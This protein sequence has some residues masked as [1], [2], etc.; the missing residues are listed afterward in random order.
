MSRATPARG[1]VP[2]PK[3][4]KCSI[5]L[6]GRRTEK[7]VPAFPTTPSLRT[8]AF[9]LAVYLRSGEKPPVCPYSTTRNKTGHSNRRLDLTEV[10]TDECAPTWRLEWK[11][12]SSSRQGGARVA[13]GV[14]AVASA[15]DLPSFLFFFA[16]FVVVKRAT[17]WL[18]QRVGVPHPGL[19]R[20][21]GKMMSRCFFKRRLC[22]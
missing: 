8:R 22:G 13:F 1:H 10:R 21:C 5:I 12:D 14:A 16:I 15:R 19:P 3:H 6:A 17:S 11:L 20:L 4:R 9:T 18:S 7:V 2:V